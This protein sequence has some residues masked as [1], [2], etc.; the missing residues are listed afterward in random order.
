[1]GAFCQNAVMRSG[2]WRSQWVCQ[3]RG[4]AWQWHGDG[5]GMRHRASFGSTLHDED[6]VFVHWCAQPCRM[7][8]SVVLGRDS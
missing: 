2:H 1:M 7:H 3:G 5:N 6:R 4:I 8:S